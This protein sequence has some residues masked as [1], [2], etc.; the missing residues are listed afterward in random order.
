MPRQF[1][2]EEVAVRAV[3]LHALPGRDTRS[4]APQ[5][6]VAGGAE[7]QS[8]SFTSGLVTPFS[9]SPQIRTD[10]DR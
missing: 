1:L 7:R 3:R 10:W 9:Y 2:R 4:D 8:T 6:Q 5:R